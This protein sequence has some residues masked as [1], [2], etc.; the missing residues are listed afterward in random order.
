MIIRKTVL[1]LSIITVI[2]GQNECRPCNSSFPGGYVTI[3]YQ[4]GKNSNEQRFRDLQISFAV[5]IP[6]G[7][8]PVFPFLGLTYGSRKMKDGTKQRYGDLQLNLVS[9]VAGGFGIG[10]ISSGG[11][12]H[13]RKKSWVGI[14]PLPV[15]LTKDSFFIE[16]ERLSSKGIML[17]FPMPIFG[18]AFF[19]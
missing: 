7:E 12:M 18:F 19:P 4:I 16:G 3:S 2:E 15:I 6:H 9:I 1:L 8:L 10:V 11:S 14:L 13:K 5:V 17:S